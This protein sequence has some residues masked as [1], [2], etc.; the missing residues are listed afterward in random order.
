MLR[1][2]DLGSMEMFKPLGVEFRY[3]SLCFPPWFLSEDLHRES[4]LLPL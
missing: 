4:F 1:F 3:L 2:R